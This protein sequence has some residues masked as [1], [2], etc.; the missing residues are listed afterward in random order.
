[1]EVLFSCLMTVGVEEGAAGEAS[2]WNSFS[3]V[4][5]C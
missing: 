4:E 3:I 2:E 1:M 5:E